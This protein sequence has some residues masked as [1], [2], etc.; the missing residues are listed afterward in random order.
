MRRHRHSAQFKPPLQDR[1]VSVEP[2]GRQQGAA[3][4]AGHAHHALH[5]QAFGDRLFGQRLQVSTLLLV[6]S[7]GKR[8]QLIGTGGPAIARAG[9][10]LG[11]QAAARMREQMQAR[12]GRHGAHQGQRIGNWARAHGGV[13][14]RVNPVAVMLEQLAHGLRVQRP[15]LAKGAD[16]LNKGAVHQHQ[17]RTPIGSGRHRRALAPAAFERL[18]GIGRELI[19]TRIHRAVHLQRD[20]GGG[21]PGRV[22]GQAG[23]DLK[24]AQHRLAHPATG[25]AARGPGLQPRPA[26]LRGDQH[27]VVIGRVHRAAGRPGAL[28]AHQVTRVFRVQ[29]QRGPV[30]NGEHHH[31]VARA[32]G[33]AYR[34]TPAALGADTHG[35]LDA[36]ARGPNEGGARCACRA[37]LGL[38]RDDE[39]DVF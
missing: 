5:F 14:E 4:R 37:R 35:G 17:Q 10:H 38:A 39:G 11:H 13:V 24:R 12:T 15:E 34:L 33:D 3:R 18:Q 16:G 30:G 36:A 23:D 25:R 29:V 22:F 32:R 1:Q 9:Q 19:H 26:Q 2:P 21:K 28:G 6:I 8:R 27:L 7:P 20:G 31:I